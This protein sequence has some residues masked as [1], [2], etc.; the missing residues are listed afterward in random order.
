MA[1]LFFGHKT[2]SLI[3]NT[4]LAAFLS[5]GIHIYALDDP[6]LAWFS[7]VNILTFLLM[8]KDKF[9]SK[10]KMRRTPE[11]TLLGLA[12]IGGFPGLFAGRKTFHHKTSKSS[13]ITSM[14]VLFILQLIAV[15]YFLGDI[16]SWDDAMKALGAEKKPA[17]EKTDE[18]TPL[19]A[20]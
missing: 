18:K 9:A 10:S 7:G 5:W 16:T 20:K 17:A 19:P 8:G 6:F 3:F 13:F 1:I 4:A 15:T 14:W 12:V 11:A 2:Q